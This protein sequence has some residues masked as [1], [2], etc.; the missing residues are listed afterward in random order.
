VVRLD[1]P[2]VLLDGALAVCI[3]HARLRKVCK[4][5]MSNRVS[6]GDV[7]RG[8]EINSIALQPEHYRHLHHSAY[9][10]EAGTSLRHVVLRVPSFTCL[11]FSLVIHSASTNTFN[12]I[13]SLRR[14]L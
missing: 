3:F 12:S 7:R 5:Q 4:S 2:N 9:E 13:R 11:H 6:L 14:M 8:A 10:A 1:Y